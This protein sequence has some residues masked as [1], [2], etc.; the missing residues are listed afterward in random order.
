MF[1]GLPETGS[2]W[3]LLKSPLG[4]TQQVTAQKAAEEGSLCNTHR[5][6]GNLKNENQI[7]GSALLFPSNTAS[8]AGRLVTQAASKSSCVISS[9]NLPTLQASPGT[10][11]SHKTN[12]Q[13]FNLSLW[14][15]SETQKPEVVPFSWVPSNF[16]LKL[17]EPPISTH[18][19]V[20]DL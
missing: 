1:T 9:Y 20:M 7:I 3:D 10:C 2:T 4:N 6:S 16:R 19:P 14:H 18:L 13:L 17:P 11:S 8:S 15:I 12:W 5:R